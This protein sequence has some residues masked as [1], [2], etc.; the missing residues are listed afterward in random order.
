MTLNVLHIS[1]SDAAGGAARAAYK[2]HNDLRA[3]QHHSR[4]LVARKLTGDD[5]VRR[6]KRNLAWRALDRAAGEVLDRLGFQYAFY[7]SSFAVADD[8]WFHD[9]QVVQL[10]NTHGNYFSLTALPYLSRRRPIVWLL[11]DMWAFTG[12]VAY[13]YDCERWRHGCGAC[14][15]LGEYPALPRD[16]TSLLWRMKRAVYA[17]SRLTLVTPSLWLAELARS[18][19]L[20]GQFPIHHVPY[21]VDTEVYSPGPQDEARRRLGLPADR[22][23]VLFVATDLAEQRKGFQFLDRALAGLDDPLLLAVAVSGE[24]ESAAEMRILRTQDEWLLVD[25]YRAADVVLLPTLADNFPNVVI[26]SMACSTP[27]VAFATGG[28]PDA[29]RHLET[30][31]LVRPGDTAGLAKGLRTLLGDRRLLERLGAASR[32]VA[33]AEYS[34]ARQSERYVDVYES[35]LEAA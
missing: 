31:Y 10:H 11:H 8:P 17:R 33:A 21:G 34:L 13:A 14:P 1:E 9:A 28:V 26:E 18:S 32:E 7:P 4:M 2:L 20:L 12:H 29:V 22:Q 35:M 15:Y 5:D 23:I 24:A 19:P 16:T 25:A 30:G 3:R 27:C 6:L